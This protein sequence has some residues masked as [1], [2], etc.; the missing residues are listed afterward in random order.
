MIFDPSN[1]SWPALAWLLALA[2]AAPLSAQTPDPIMP[3]SA[4]RP[5][6]K[7][8]GRTVWSGTKIETFEV[9]VISVMKNFEPKRD[10]ILTRLSGPAIERYGVV[11]GMSGSPVYIDG[12]VI[13]AVSLG[14]PFQKEAIAG[15]TP[16]EDMQ[17]TMNLPEVEH[18]GAPAGWRAPEAE[19]APGGADGR[20]A[21]PM[22]LLPIRTPLV[23]SGVPAE[24]VKRLESRFAAHN[25]V[26]IQ[27]GAGAAMLTPPGKDELQP[28]GAVGVSLVSGDLSMDAVGTLTWR[29]GDRFVAFGHPF[30]GLGDCALPIAPAFVH[31][32]M[33]SLYV[34]FKLAAAGAPVGSMCQDRPPAILGHIGRPAQQFPVAID[35]KPNERD[36]VKPYHFKVSQV[37]PMTPLLL[38]TLADSV[39][40]ANGRT[41]G[42]QSFVTKLELK[43]AGRAPL[44]YTNMFS[45]REDHMGA[46]MEMFTPVLQILTNKFEPVVIESVNLSIEAQERSREARIE[47][48]RLDHVELERGETAEAAVV[49]RTYGGQREAVRMKFAV[50]LDAQPGNAQ[51]VVCDA[52]QGKS[53]AAARNPGHYQ[54]T[55]L[56]GVINM[57]REERHNNEVVL[58]LMLPRDGVSYTGKELPRLP[59]SALSVISASGLS[60]YKSLQS[61]VEVR[62]PTQHAVQ[63]VETLEVRIRE[64]K[65]P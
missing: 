15:V 19:S 5:G 14:W 58:Q 30:M 48:V 9:T 11:A 26:P 40:T 52:Q 6:M 3:L 37:G 31:S 33:P 51:L 41:G 17:A 7:G 34:S 32:V 13:G 56:E 46:V 47:S 25:L 61:E 10:I 2:L 8:I 23:L 38:L 18:P 29:D 36:P 43:L 24:T 35:I 57:G 50:P 55:S 54:P 60:G 21:N 39:I 64:Q 42:D 65:Q 1:R 59:A 20:S 49:L 4:I 22:G 44:T 62:Q 45:T 27:G 28:G 16:I 63:G 53:R 12:K